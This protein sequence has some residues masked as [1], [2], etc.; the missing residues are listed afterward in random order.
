MYGVFKLLS[1]WLVH[2]STG[3]AS[4]PSASVTTWFQLQKKW[5]WTLMG[6][7]N[8]VFVSVCAMPGIL[9]NAPR[10]MKGL[11]ELTLDII[12]ANTGCVNHVIFIWGDITFIL[13]TYMIT[14][15]PWTSL[16]WLLPLQDLFQRKKLMH[17]MRGMVSIAW[18]P[19]WWGKEHSV[20][21]I[22]SLNPCLPLNV[23]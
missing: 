1:L 4:L 14:R 6:T 19:W 15:L 11:T 10:N 18:Q 20:W 22:L 13:W 23:P 5:F 2:L 17:A 21:G 12:E 7:L 8:N 9:Q 3:L 16:A